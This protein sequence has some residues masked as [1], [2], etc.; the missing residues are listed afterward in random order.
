MGMTPMS[1]LLAFGGVSL[2]MAAPVAVYAQANQP[3]GKIVLAAGA[4]QIVR[5]GTPVQA[6]M[7]MD[8]RP[9]DTVRTAPKSTAQL[10][11][12]DGGMI[13]VREKSEFRLDSFNYKPGAPPSSMTSVASVV[14]GGARFLT[15]AV[16]KA[17][18]KAVT[19][20]TRV[21]TIG[22]RGTGYDLI[23]CVDQ[24][25]EENGAAAK[26]GL[27][28]SV[29]E[30]TILVTNEAGETNVLTTE[31]F[32]IAERQASLIKL[33]VQPS[34]LAE[35]AP[36]EGGGKSTSEVAAVDVPVD[37]P[38]SETMQ[39]S[40]VATEKVAEIPMPPPQQ[41]DSLTTPQT[42]YSQVGLGNGAALAS[43]A[44]AG[45]TLISAE[46]NPSDGQQNIENA[47]SGLRVSYTGTQVSSM[48]VP[49]FPNFP[50]YVIR[51]YTATFREGGADAGVLAWGRWADGSLLIGNWSG[52][53]AA[54]KTVTLTAEQ[55]FHWIV[56]ET[57]TSLPG[58]GV[59]TF[60][61]IGATTP[62]EARVGALAGW[63]VT[64]GTLTAD[65]PNARLSGN[66]TLYLA[67]DEGYGYFNLD[68][69]STS[70]LKAGSPT[71]ISTSVTRLNGSAPLCTAVCDGIGQVLLYGN[72]AGKPASHAGMTYNFNTGDY[73]VMGAAVFAR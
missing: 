51:G 65:V 56:G 40:Q 16:G 66:M 3:A 54:P 24:C 23:D 31:N 53:A 45:F 71:A 42:V 50:G 64:A 38:S 30:G 47:V 63:S 32:F 59:Y 36:V 13:S 35:P 44:S 5:G 9:G 26:P 10:W 72:L 22:I 28:G 46:Y 20:N 49:L 39:V 29:Y 57:A 69:A 25:F 11:L 73:L 1:R 48:T 15:G 7:G 62:T 19:V 12:R 52:S 17:N 61:L 18:P 21:A 41:A 33:P 14:K 4:V 67:R 37:V 6:K 43:S 60:N 55:G 58:N 27:Y 68:F 8:I 34:F 2:C 70:Q